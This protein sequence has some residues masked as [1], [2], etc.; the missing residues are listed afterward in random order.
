ME[1]YSHIELGILEKT[2]LVYS[3]KLLLEL[4]AV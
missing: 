4:H 3:S 2:D 1:C